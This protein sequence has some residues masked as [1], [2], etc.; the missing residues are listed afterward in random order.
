[1]VYY[2]KG[3]INMNIAA[4]EVPFATVEKICGCKDK[5][6]RKITYSFTDS[7]YSLCIDKRDI[8]FAELQACELLLK[9]ALDENDKNT[10][11]REIAELRIMLDLMH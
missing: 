3:E 9:Y 6:S 4:T 8:I 7:Y 5:N 1:M 11:L 10:V 2:A